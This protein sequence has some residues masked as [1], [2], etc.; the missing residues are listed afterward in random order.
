ASQIGNEAA[1]GIQLPRSVQL[2]RQ[3]RSVSNF[4]VIA[5]RFQQRLGTHQIISELLA[6]EPADKLQSYFLCARA[7]SGNKKLQRPNPAI[8]R[9]ALHPAA[10]PRIRPSLGGHL[11]TSESL[12]LAL[13]C[14]K[15]QRTNTDRPDEIRAFPQARF[16]RRN[17]ARSERQDSLG[18]R[19]YLVDDP[20]NRFLG[21]F[22]PF[23]SRYA[24]N[25]TL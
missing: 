15:K 23:H 12:F 11:P 2:Q 22:F 8:F 7:H 3:S 5:E 25:P 21:P 1:H 18:K 24:R 9:H 19:F 16:C 10:C 14:L 20:E 13:H 6:V 17:S 4:P